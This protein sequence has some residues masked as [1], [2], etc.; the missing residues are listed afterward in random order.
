MTNKLII[1]GA[2]LIMAA[3]VYSFTYLRPLNLKAGAS[4]EQITWHSWEEVQELNKK[5]PK[6]VFV[7]VY[8]DW[9]GWCK[10]MDQSTF[11][12]PKVIEVMNEH[13]YAVKFNAEQ[14]EPATYQGQSLNFR[15]GGK[16]GVHE[17]AVV[18]L[19]GRLGY[20]SFAY[21]DTEMK[22]LHVSPGYKTP[23]QMLE[24]L[25]QLAKR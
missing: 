25:E 5:K 7:D 14:K 11:T 17:L 15:P 16:R 18:L 2:I 22:P 1:G 19:N 3:I 13:F 24:E 12:D 23:D 8:T 20:P 4:S 6:K 21:L 10:K 9:C